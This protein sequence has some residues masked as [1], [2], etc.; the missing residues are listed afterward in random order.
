MSGRRKSCLSSTPSRLLPCDMRAPL[1]LLTAMI[2]LVLRR[3]LQSS[4]AVAVSSVRL[5]PHFC[6]VCTS[7]ALPL[8]QRRLSY[9]PWDVAFD[10][11]APDCSMLTKLFNGTTC[12]TV[13][14]PPLHLATAS[15]R[16]PLAACG[17]SV[18]AGETLGVAFAAPTSQYEYLIDVSGATV[19]PHHSLCKVLFVSSLI[20]GT[21]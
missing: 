21:P 6:H 4:P 17:A 5:A 16:P 7:S 9:S 3:R 15:C 10:R 19:C 8:L 12:P 2:L 11:S 20:P 14:S 1:I 13:T 18:T